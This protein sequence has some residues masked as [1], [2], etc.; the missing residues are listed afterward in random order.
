MYC[1]DRVGIP[2]TKPF[3]VLAESFGLQLL[4]I[5]MYVNANVKFHDY[6]IKIL[7]L[8]IVI[9]T[10]HLHVVIAALIVSRIVYAL[11]LR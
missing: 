3:Q 8:C 2:P 1:N 11:C 9:S 6:V 4:G 5:Y 7:S 10:K